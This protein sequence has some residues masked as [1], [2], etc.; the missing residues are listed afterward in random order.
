MSY[1]G[2]QAILLNRCDQTVGVVVDPVFGKG[3][4][5]QSIFPSN[6]LGSRIF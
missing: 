5:C 1:A 4:L 2:K 3:G 6:S